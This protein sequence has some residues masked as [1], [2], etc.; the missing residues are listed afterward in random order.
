MAGITQAKPS[1]PSGI[2]SKKLLIFLKSPILATVS[3][4]L[5][6]NA[7]SVAPLYIA[8]YFI[9]LSNIFNKMITIATGYKTES[10]GPENVIIESTPFVAIIPLN[11][12]VNITIDLYVNLPFVRSEKNSPAVAVR[13]MDVVKQAKATVKAKAA[14]PY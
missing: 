9:L 3:N 1:D 12:Q 2:L 11:K 7:P 14:V 13:P 5:A 10:I 4:K 8:L 6:I